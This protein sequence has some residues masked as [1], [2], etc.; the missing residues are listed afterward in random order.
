[1]SVHCVRCGSEI[2]SGQPCCLV[3]G[4]EAGAPAP[5]AAAPAGRPTAP[6]RKRVNGCVIA[7]M[8]CAICVAITITGVFFVGRALYRMPGGPGEPGIGAVGTLDA[9]EDTKG[10]VMLVR[11][12]HDMEAVGA[13]GIAGDAHNDKPA[14]ALLESGRVF[15]ALKGVQATVLGKG[16]DSEGDLLYHVRLLDGPQK[17]KDGWVFRMWFVPRAA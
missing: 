15:I 3:C 13:A 16:V 14:E 11:T 2:T 5:A 17:G 9:D 1:M 8:I 7:I 4:L 6:P 10:Q 12:P